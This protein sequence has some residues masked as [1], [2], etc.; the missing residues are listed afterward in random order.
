MINDYDYPRPV[1]R[2][3][4][5]QRPV[6]FHQLVMDGWNGIA[7]RTCLRFVSG[8]DA[9]IVARR[10]VHANGGHTRY[11]FQCIYCGGD[12]VSKCYK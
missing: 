12:W 2:V 3:A 9:K 8:F 5:R 6:K 11:I 10:V 1:G 4:R 7:Q